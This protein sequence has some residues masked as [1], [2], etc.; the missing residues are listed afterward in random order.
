MSNIWFTSDLHLG[1]EKV[2]ELRGFESTMA[3]DYAVS[4][5]WIERVSD[6]DTVWVLGDLCMSDPEYA[7]KCIANLPGTKHLIAGNHD[8]CHPMHRRAHKMQPRYFGPGRFASVQPFARVK[9][10]GTDVMLSHFPYTADRGETR[11]P[12]WRL[13]DLGGWLLHGHT[14]LPEVRTGPREIHVGL[15][16]WGLAPVQLGDIERVMAE[17][18]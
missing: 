11:Y 17:E 13:P 3:H 12:Q 4:F 18:L 16:A 5:R 15:D 9:V 14:H 2:A 10:N 8:A 7:L 1:H 6:R